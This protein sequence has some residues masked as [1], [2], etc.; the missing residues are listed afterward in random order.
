MYAHSVLQLHVDGN[1]G[2]PLSAD[3]K[4]AG[5]DILACLCRIFK[6]TSANKYCWAWSGGTAVCQYRLTWITQLRTN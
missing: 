2:S 1:S 6:R 4:L 5:Y 3:I